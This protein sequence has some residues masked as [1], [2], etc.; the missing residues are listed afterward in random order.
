MKLKI[1]TKQKLSEPHSEK[2]SET[3]SLLKFRLPSQVGGM[4]LI[5][6]KYTNNLLLTTNQNCSTLGGF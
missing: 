3:L 1:R 4:I 2:Y 5:L 6:I